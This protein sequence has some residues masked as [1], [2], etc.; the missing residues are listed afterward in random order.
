M[1]IGASHGSNDMGTWARFA[2]FI[3]RN[4]LWEAYR[5]LRGF[6]HPPLMG[7]MASAL[8]ALATWSDWPFR[9]WW[10]LPPLLADLCAMQLL[11]RHFTPRGGLWAAASV[12][13]FSCNPIS[14]A[15]TAFHGNTDSVCAVFALYAALLHGRGRF[16]AAG[17]ALA[18]AANVKVIA[19]I[20]APG[21][22]LL[23]ATPLQS[24]RFFGGFAL[25]CLPL[26]L[27]LLVAP[28]FY[29]NVFGY[30]SQINRWGVSAWALHSQR[31]YPALH[32]FLTV[33]YRAAARSLILGVTLSLAFIGR[34]RRWSAV[35]IGT[36]T[37]ASFLFLT[38]GFGV[39][40]LVW[41]VPLLAAVSLRHSAWWAVSAGS[42]LLLTYD[43]FM[44]EEWPLRSIHRLPIEEPMGMLGLL[45]WVVI[46]MFLY[47][48]LAKGYAEQYLRRALQPEGDRLL[49]PPIREGSMSGEAVAFGPAHPAR[50]VEAPLAK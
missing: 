37:M 43:N 18:G 42:F 16:V 21:Y 25:G 13:A 30:D 40:Y 49:R 35:R 39:Q 1:V 32:Q 28:D 12:A 7:L 48:E 8:N 34:R 44:T 15:V 26:A 50:D 17:L 2:A 47:E 29:A 31:T 45:A 46:G 23:C 38:P 14:I 33:E 27:A 24:L 36:V 19:L 22:L 20:F 5:Q 10:K 41:I 9:I 3:E 11:W 4:G 6:N